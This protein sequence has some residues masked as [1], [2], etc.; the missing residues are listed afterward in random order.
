MQVREV[1]RDSIKLLC[2]NTL[3]YDREFS[4]EGLLGITIDNQEIFLV[5]INDAFTK[6]QPEET[7]RLVVSETGFGAASTTS[8]SSPP[9][10]TYYHHGRNSFGRRTLGFPISNHRRKRKRFS[11]IIHGIANNLKSSRLRE[12]HENTSMSSNDDFGPKINNVAV[13][14]NTSDS[15]AHGHNLTSSGEEAL[16]RLADCVGRIDNSPETTELP[17]EETPWNLPSE[18]T[19]CE[20]EVKL[21][22]DLKEDNADDKAVAEQHLAASEGGV[23]MM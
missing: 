22:V 10:A 14:R 15:Y 12:Q 16:R 21:E 19:S 8:L 13:H 11:G 7:D 18:S 4:V 2:K 23:C 3:K 5:N 6:P 1:L 9:A 20:K 17:E